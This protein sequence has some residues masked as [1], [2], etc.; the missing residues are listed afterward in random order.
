MLV[1]WLCATVSF[2]PPT[3][4]N[5]ISLKALTATDCGVNLVLHSCVWTVSCSSKVAGQRPWPLTST[6]TI[7][8]SVGVSPPYQREVFFGANRLFYLGLFVQ[9][10]AKWS[11]P[12]S[13]F[14]FFHF[15]K[16]PRQDV[17]FIFYIQELYFSSSLSHGSSA[18]EFVSFTC[19]INRRRILLLPSAEPLLLKMTD[20]CLSRL[21]YFEQIS[22]P[23]LCKK[24]K[25]RRGSWIHH[26]SSSTLMCLPCKPRARIHPFVCLQWVVIRLL[27][28]YLQCCNTTELNQLTALY[29]IHWII[30]I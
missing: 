28:A 27:A 20:A 26:H 8:I 9:E 16:C 2:Y 4:Q 1:P 19:S 6:R 3:C 21:S 5:N 13:I 29:S 12:A 18:F 14:L 23:M 11:P 17:D 30:V 15:P 7:L 22:N 25:Y 24:K 10:T